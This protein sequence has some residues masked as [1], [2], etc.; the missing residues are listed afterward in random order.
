[1]PVGK[2]YSRSRAELAVRLRDALIRLDPEESSRAENII[3]KRLFEC[4]LQG[5][6]E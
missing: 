5:E 1:L 3:A 6:A 4:W 2:P